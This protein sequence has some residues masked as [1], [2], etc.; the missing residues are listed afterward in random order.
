MMKLITRKAFLSLILGL[1]LLTGVCAQTPIKVACV[2]N[3]ITFGYGLKPGESYPAKL[4]QLMGDKY[5]VRNYGISSRTLL[6]KGDHPYWI[7]QKYQ[8]VLAWNPDIVIIKLGTNDTKP[9]NWKYKDEFLSDYVDFINSF[10]QLASHPKIYVCYPIP[11]FINKWGITDSIVTNGIIPNVKI[12]A[13][14][15]NSTIID[16]NKAFAGKGAMV[17]DGVHPNKDGAEFLAGFI[18]QAIK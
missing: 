12:A 13:G 15:T 17:F 5:E 1:F 18:Y 6:K 8:E 7:E 14:K 10:K 4:Q 11:V 16:L 2:G 9:Q 3:S